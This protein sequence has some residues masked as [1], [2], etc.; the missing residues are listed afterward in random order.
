MGIVIIQSSL[1]L[2]DLQG[3]LKICIKSLR[4]INY[5]TKFTIFLEL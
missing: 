1:K 5:K 4:L 2:V 3:F